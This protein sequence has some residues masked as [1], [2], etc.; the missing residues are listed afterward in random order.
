[1]LI[2]SGYGDDEATKLVTEAAERGMDP[3]RFAARLARKR[4]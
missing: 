3:E 2:R 4:R 1:M